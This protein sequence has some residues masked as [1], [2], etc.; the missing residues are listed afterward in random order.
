MTYVLGWRSKDSVFLTADMVTTY[1]GPGRGLHT[2]Y[3]TFGEAHIAENNRVIQEEMNKIVVVNDTLALTF[4]G[5][6]PLAR[7]II[8]IVK[9][10]VG[11]SGIH[12]INDISH[13]FKVAVD[14]VSPVALSRI[15]TFIIAATID[16]EPVLLTF[17]AQDHC[18]VLQHKYLVQ[19]GSIKWLY[20]KITE[21]FYREQASKTMTDPTRLVL[22]NSLI[23]IYGVHD[24]LLEQ[25]VGGA[26]LGLYLDKNGVHWQNDT[27]YVIYSINT[28]GKANPQSVRMAVRENAV[29]L[30]SPFRGGVSAFFAPTDDSNIG[31]WKAKWINEWSKQFDSFQFDYV[32]FLAKEYRKITVVKNVKEENGLGKFVRFGKADGKT[33]EVDVSDD[34]NTKLV[35]LVPASKYPQIPFEWTLVC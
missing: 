25:G 3:S 10:Q 11:L 26:V 6:I 13:A 22:I 15:P 33:V 1:H 31:L 18:Q 7:E 32:V 23:Q 30:G 16:N 17:S 9:L 29:I 12:D 8:R 5:D 19:A 27:C 35:S 4:T 24:H 20:K 21:L 14:S 28:L 34:L 2:N